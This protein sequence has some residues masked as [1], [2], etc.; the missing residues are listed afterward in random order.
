MTQGV[1]TL[2][3]SWKAYFKLAV[4]K[5]TEVSP[6]Y[7]GHLTCVQFVEPCC[8]VHCTTNHRFIDIRKMLIVSMKSVNAN[9]L[10]S[11]PT[12]SAFQEDTQTQGIVLYTLDVHLCICIYRVVCIHF[13]Q[14]YRPFSH[15]EVRELTLNHTKCSTPD[16]PPPTS[17][18]IVNNH[19]T[20]LPGSLSN[21]E[22]ET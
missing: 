17:L 5:A 18:S 3:A 7:V 14:K 15:E 22:K 11:L 19:M 12:W 21:A 4:L 8:L 20:N 13:F 10:F 16:L 6:T 1:C 9:A 2:F